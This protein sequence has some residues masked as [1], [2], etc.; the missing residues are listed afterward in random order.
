MAY[1]LGVSAS[2][3]GHPIGM[4]VLMEGDDFLV[5]RFWLMT[6]A[7]AADYSPGLSAPP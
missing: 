7:D 6:N 3:V 4:F 2:K 1:V 5:H